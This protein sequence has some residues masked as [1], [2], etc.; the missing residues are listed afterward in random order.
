MTH[1]AAV[2]VSGISS[3]CP[4]LAKGALAILA[5][6]A[7]SKIFIFFF[8]NLPVQPSPEVWC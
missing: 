2:L 8:L 3:W 5:T 6:Y 4:A 1:A 7:L